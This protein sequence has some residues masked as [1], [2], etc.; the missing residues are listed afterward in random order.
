MPYALPNLKQTKR[1]LSSLQLQADHLRDQ[2]AEME[3]AI[4][5]AQSNLKLAIFARKASSRRLRRRAVDGPTKG[6]IAVT[7]EYMK[8]PR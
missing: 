8:R 7:I 6:D 1:K 2:L 4:S 3:C 5:R